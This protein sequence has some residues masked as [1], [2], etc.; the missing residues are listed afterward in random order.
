MKHLERWVCVYFSVRDYVLL[1]VI[2]TYLEWLTQKASIYFLSL[3]KKGREAVPNWGWG[4]CL[5]PSVPNVFSSPNSLKILMIGIFP[6][7]ILSAFSLFL[8][9]SCFVPLVF[10]VRSILQIPDAQWLPEYIKRAAS[11]WAVNL[12]AKLVGTYWGEEVG[13]WQGCCLLVHM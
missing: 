4:C 9:L 1:I 7:S 2:K 11:S 10:S 13:G 12:T 3:H 8:F 5:E 6:K